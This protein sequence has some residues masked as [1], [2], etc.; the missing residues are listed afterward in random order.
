[1]DIIE[2]IAVVSTFLCVALTSRQNIWC[3]P[4]G[5]VGVITFFMVFLEQKLYAET[6]LQVIFFA[7]AIYGWYNWVKGNG[8]DTLP[9]TKISNDRFITDIVTTSILAFGIGYLLDNLTDTTQPYLDSYTSCISLLA[10]W[11]LTKKYIQAWYLWIV[12][13]VLLIIMFINQGLNLSALL[14]LAMLGFSTYGLTQWKRNL[15]TV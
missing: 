13:D 6:V 14:Y 8:S 15:K 11:Y 12:V 4:V 3:W 1:M 9:V 5:S 7:Q 10:N 2:I